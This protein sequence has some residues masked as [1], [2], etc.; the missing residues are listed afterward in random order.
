M[1]VSFLF[2]FISSALYICFGVTLEDKY[3]SMGNLILPIVGLSWVMAVFYKPKRTD[4]S[5]KR[6]L[7]FHFFT[8]AVVC[9]VSYAVSN[10]RLGFPFH[11]WFAIFRI[12]IWCLT[13]WLGLKLRESAAKLPPQELSDFLCQTVL[14]KGTA[15]MGPMLFF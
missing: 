11:G 4:A 14:V 3:E 10:F 7:Y 2:A 6:F 12:P 1:G 8:F 13:F 9:E 15:A 5:Y